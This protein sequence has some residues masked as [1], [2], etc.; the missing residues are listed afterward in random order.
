M[1]GTV[2]DNIARA[3]GVIASA[4]GGGVW[5]L[6]STQTASGDTE[7]DFTTLSSDYLDF[8]VTGSG[9]R[10]SDD[11]QTLN[12][13][14][15]DA[16]PT[17]ITAGDYV[18]GFT[19]YDSDSNIK[20]NAA[21]PDSS[22]INAAPTWSW[23]NET[24]SSMW[25]EA[26][27]SNFHDTDLYTNFWCTTIFR[28]DNSPERAQPTSGGGILNQAQTIGGIRFYPGAGTLEVGEFTLY[29]RK[30]T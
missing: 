6:I 28:T 29:G 7:I 15:F 12:I 22:W 24:A 17:I 1:S 10:Q 9:I 8:R 11:A 18:F 26:T 5:T 3:S 16:T 30:I 19:G 2:G 20:S 25:F 4:A 27:F 14:L 13:R 21:Q 23:G